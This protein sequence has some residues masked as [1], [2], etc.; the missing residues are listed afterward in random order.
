MLVEKLQLKKFFLLEL[1][2]Y[3]TQIKNKKAKKWRHGP[4]ISNEELLGMEGGSGGVGSDSDSL[5]L[6]S[7]PETIFYK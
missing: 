2:V 3:R 6:G 4:G 7:S 5:N 1:M